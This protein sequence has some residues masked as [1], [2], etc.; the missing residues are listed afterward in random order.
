MSSDELN[1]DNDP[2][3]QQYAILMETNDLEGESWYY[4]IKYNENIDN[5]KHL[6]SQLEQIDWYLIDDISTFDLETS[7]LVSAVTAKE[8][9][10]VDLN[11]YSFHRKFDGKLKQITFNL[12]DSNESNM[13]TVF[14]KLGYGRIENYISDEDIDEDDLT[15]CGSSDENE[16]SSDQNSDQDDSDDVLP[17]EGTP[18]SIL[19]STIKQFQSKRRKKRPGFT[20]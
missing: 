20:E 2:I 7:H 11:A 12:G 6:Q 1:T 15:E 10:K 18:K 5:L 17:D 3:E 16:D 9:T 14:D 13:N 4:F 19:M 8:M